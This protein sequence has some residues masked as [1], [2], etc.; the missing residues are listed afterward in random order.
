MSEYARQ[1][2]WHMSVPDLLTV[3]GTF[4]RAGTIMP[5]AA[6]QAML[7]AHYGI[8]WQ[9]G[10]QTSAAGS[11]YRKNGDDGDIDE[12]GNLQ[13][14]QSGAVFLPLDMECV[15]F[16]NSPSANDLLDVISGAFV[17]SLVDKQ[18]QLGDGPGL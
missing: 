17:A 14:E 2:G 10:P 3:M 18:P 12:K 9:H 16:V 11:L 8:D 13:V 7:D 15:V 5:Q 4:R 6:A 1:A